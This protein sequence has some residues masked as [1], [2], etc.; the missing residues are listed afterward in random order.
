LTFLSVLLLWR[1]F[2]RF[3]VST[4]VPQRSW[5]LVESSWLDRYPLSLDVSIPN[6]PI[7]PAISPA[8]HFRLFPIHNLAQQ[9]TRHRIAMALTIFLAPLRL[10]RTR[11][12]SCSTP[13]H[14]RKCPT[15]LHVCFL[16]V[17]SSDYCQ[18]IV[19]PPRSLSGPRRAQALRLSTFNCEPVNCELLLPATAP[20]R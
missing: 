14:Q 5:H 11:H 1:P 8:F 12:P 16:F 7:D 17:G 19:I 4:E 2:F 15:G 18:R 6:L 13:R 3:V 20:S 10:P 9:R